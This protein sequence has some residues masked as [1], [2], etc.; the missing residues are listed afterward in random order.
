MDRKMKKS[1]LANLPFLMLLSFG[2][3][4]NSQLAIPGSPRHISLGE[5]LVRV[6]HDH[7]EYQI[8][9]TSPINSSGSAARKIIRFNIAEYDPEQ[10]S[11]RF[12]KHCSPCSLG[13]LNNCS[14]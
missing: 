7:G 1:F 6:E 9:I 3:W 11:H 8:F 2:V 13:Q 10:F 14:Y 12:I 4:E 5:N